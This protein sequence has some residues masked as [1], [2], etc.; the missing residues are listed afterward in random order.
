MKK[1]ADKIK[2]VE[3]LRKALEKAK[4]IF[5]NGF[6]K[7]T[8]SQDFELRKVVRGAGAHYQVV[9][10]NLAAKASE[11]TPA[12]QLLGNLKG[13]TSLAFTESDPVALAKAL[14]AYAKTNPAFTFRSGMVEGRVINLASIQELSALPSRE[15]IL[16][17]LL[18]LIQ[19][20]AQRL[21]SVV[22]AVGRNVAVVVDQG[23]KENKFQA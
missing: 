15:E 1:K 3:A 6:D 2:D 22:N 17:K 21:V 20:P 23:I 16:S 12:G 14:S 13:M 19:A 18:F 4:H 5:V 9:K 10:N 11:G 7:L 8:V